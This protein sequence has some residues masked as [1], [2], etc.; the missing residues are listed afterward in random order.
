VLKSVHDRADDQPLQPDAHEAGQR[1]G[2]EKTAVGAEPDQ[3][4]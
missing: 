4:V 1:D 3:G 2:Q